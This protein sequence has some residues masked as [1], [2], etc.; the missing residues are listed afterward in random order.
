MMDMPGKKYY[1]IHLDSADIE[2]TVAQG[3]LWEM[4]TKIE[5]LWK[6]GSPGDL[7][8]IS[9]QDYGEQPD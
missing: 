6:E 1:I 9:S 8:F 5:E 7:Y 4:S 2:R 3:S